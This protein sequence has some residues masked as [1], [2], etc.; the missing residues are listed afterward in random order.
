[1]RERK[2]R[3]GGREIGATTKESASLTSSCVMARVVAAVTEKEKS[4]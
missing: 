4:V 2:E 1:V 3:E